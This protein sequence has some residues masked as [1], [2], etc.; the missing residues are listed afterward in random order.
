MERALARTVAK[1]H[2]SCMN[3]SPAVERARFT[4]ADYR[5]WPDDERW[6]IIGGEA[7]AMSPAPATR[8]QKLLIRLASAFETFL[9]GNR[10]EV[11]PA[12]TDLKLSDIDVVQPDLMVVCEPDKVRPTHVEGPPTLV[13]EILSPSTE[14]LDRGRKLDLYAASGVKE[15]WLVTP[16]PALLEIFVLDNGTYRRAHAFTREQA[17]R[18]PSFPELKLDLNALFDLPVA[19]R[20][21]GSTSSAKA[22]RHTP[23]R[24]EAKAGSLRQP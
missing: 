19:R 3:T 5:T 1:G 7:Y 6:Q 23:P 11:Y 10:C 8:H 17:F 13:I 16:Y 2:S 9:R 18:C 20:K 22:I 12:P 24:A 21:N 4:W 15:V 14:V